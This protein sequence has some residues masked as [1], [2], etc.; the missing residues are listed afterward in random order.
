M[1]KTKVA[2]VIGSLAALIFLA[3]IYLVASR[4]Q[5]S[6]TRPDH[7]SRH[8]AQHYPIPKDFNSAELKSLKRRSLLGDPGAAD[9][10]R[11]IYSNCLGHYSVANALRPSVS[12][13][14]CRRAHSQWTEVAAANGS[15]A[16][17]IQQYNAKAESDDCVEVYRA[18]Y[19]LRKIPRNLM[20][21]EPWVSETK[22]QA[23]REKACGW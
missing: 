15:P 6:A 12:E 17:I 11:E 9:R 21:Q 7:S 16:G 19:W 18:G 22:R 4:G 1:R 5:R 13:A 8:L 10:L 2:V 14:E 23:Q 3:L 20:T